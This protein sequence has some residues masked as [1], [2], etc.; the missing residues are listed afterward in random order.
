MAAWMMWDFVEIQQTDDAYIYRSKHNLG[1]LFLPLAGFSIASGL[2]V[3][4]Q[5]RLALVPCAAFVGLGLYVGWTGLTFD[6]SN[7]HVRVWR[8]GVYSEWGSVDDPE[9]AE[10]NFRELDTLALVTKRV[11]DSERRWV[12]GTLKNGDTIKMP[13]NDLVQVALKRVFAYASTHDLQI[14][15]EDLATGQ[16]DR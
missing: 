15:F 1:L 11:G 14:E 9:S 10:L 16:S 2:F 6:T 4:R 8:D 5:G 7:H 12:V 13:V 3:A